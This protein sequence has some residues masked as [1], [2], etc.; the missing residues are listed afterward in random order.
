MPARTTVV[1]VARQI[2]VIE[3]AVATVGYALLVGTCTQFFNQHVVTYTKR[4]SSVAEG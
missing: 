4:G 1:M 2:L 3:I